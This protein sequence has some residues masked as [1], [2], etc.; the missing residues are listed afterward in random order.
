MITL[1]YFAAVLAAQKSQ[2]PVA[3]MPPFDINRLRSKSG[4]ASR[5]AGLFLGDPRW[6]LALLR[7]FKPNVGFGNFLLVT[8]GADVRDILERGDEF[9]TP[10]GPEMA[11][12]ARGS[13]FILGMQDGAAYRQ[14]KSAVLSAFPPAEVE[15]AVRPIAERHSRDIMTRA[16]PGFDAIAGLMKIVPVR[17]CRDYFGLEIDDET[18]FADWSIA[19]SALFFSDPTANPTTRQLAVVAGDR[20]IKVIDRSIAAIRER[21]GKDDRPLARLVALMDQGRLS[22][23]DIHSIMLGMVA[24]FVPTNVL[25]GGNCLDV[26]LSRTDARQ[27]VDEAIAAG[28][29]GKLDRA[30]ME[31]MRFKPIWIGPW[32]YT[33]RDAVIGKGTRRERLVKAGTVV[34]PATLSAM[35]DPEIVQRPNE[36]DTSRP[37]RDYMV[38]GYGIHLCIGAEIARTQIG[39]CVR[40]LFSKPKLARARGRTGKMVDVGAYPANLKVDFER[41]ALCRTTDQSMVTVVCPITRSMPLDVVRGK[42]EDLGNPPAGEI[43]EALD[44]VGTIHFTSLAVAATGKDE[45]SGLESGALVLEISG[46]GSADDVIAAIAQAIGQRLRPIFRDVC[47][48][49]DGGT[50]EDFLKKHNIEISPSFGSTAGLVFAGTPGHSVRRILAEAKL[51]DSVREIAEKPR[52]G[53]GNAPDVLA[54]ARQHVRCLGQFN[55]A[56][57]PAE[58]LLERPPGNWKRA[59]TTTLLVPPVFATV[60]IILAASWYMTYH[61]VFGRPVDLSHVTLTGVAVAVT[62]LVLALAG[63]LIFAAL[64]ALLGLRALQRLDDNDQPE[65]TSIAPKDLDRILAREDLAAQNHLTAIST[66]KAGIL[67]RLALRFSFYLISIAAQKVFKPGFLANINTIHFARWVLLPGTDRLVFFSNYGGSWESYLEDFIAKASEG[68]TGVWSN[69]VGYPRTRWLFLD[70]ARDGDRFKRWARRQQVPT[71]FWYSAYPHLNTARIRINSRIRRGIAS[72]TGNEARDWLSLFGSL[73][74]PQARP[75]DA[76]GPAVPTPTPIEEL[77]SGEIQ[78]IFFGPFGA[79]GHAH[80]LAVQV[81]E[82]LPATKRKAWLDFV[83]GKTS[84]GDGVPAG[85]AMTVAFGPCGL[86]R[87][88]LEGGVDDNPLDTFPV[89]FRQGMGTPERSRILDDTGRDGPSTWQWGAPDTR[90]DAIIVCYAEAPATLKTEVAAVKRQTAGAG[91]S[92]VAELPLIVKREPKKDGAAADEPGKNGDGT[93]HGKPGRLRA[94]EHFGFVDGVSQPIVRG[95]ARANRGAAPMHLVA[96]GEF[97]FGYR[98]E[99]GFY[100]ASPSVKAAQDRTGILSQVRRN[101]QV[102]GQPPPPRDFGRNG[103]FLVVRQFEQHVELFDDFCRKAAMQAAGETGDP[104]ITPRWIAAKMLGRWQDGSSLVRN[105]NGRPG[106]GADNDFALGAEDPQGHACP[107][108]SHI[109]RSNPRDSLG[110]D[111][112]TQIR[113]GK[114][115]R[116][117]RVGRTYEKKEKGGRTEKGLLF[118]CLN[119]DIERQYEF[120][121]QTWVSS[122]SFQGLVDEKDPTIG[123]RKSGGRFSIPSWEKVTVIKDIPQFVTTRG[124][125]Y[126]FMPSRSALRYLISRL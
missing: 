19:L 54:E 125:G 31:A 13:N 114:R 106:R 72:A 71:L 40:A 48:L 119:A 28:D 93:S 78:S 108:G 82:G 116:I 87:L 18:E 58:S 73:P 120:I 21:T 20:L 95:T 122:S 52:A 91:M 109:R 37:H 14:M 34:M 92:L 7:R 107:L 51:A 4:I 123:S 46:D 3:D 101:R 102:P 22:L 29:T 39:E 121:Q 38:F 80:M 11:E 36:F 44:K 86:R 89:A 124:G 99:H 45:K 41:S 8:K 53:T 115:H 16:S 105:P 47:G 96:P 85:R 33:R 110:E 68:L 15:A 77:E 79:L 32:R 57:E 65:N 35:F 6:L 56:F 61:L 98:D 1:K 81:P 74:R 42:I 69:T 126:F 94:Y 50:L 55:W 12:L 25:A 113:I 9:E 118:M 76:A 75:E 17:I 111:R 90:V 70:G 2:R 23:P 112:E 49:P 117:L 5:I 10:Y 84:F 67:R 62:S 83:M 97:L 103:S 59:F 24:G 60:A 63:L 104:A 64:L 26:I 27:A 43:R 88:G 66:M 30:I 100:P